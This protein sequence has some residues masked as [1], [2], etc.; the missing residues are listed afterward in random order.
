[1]I[2]QKKLSQN[3]KKGGFR[4]LFLPKNDF[5]SCSA[6]SFPKIMKILKAW[7]PANDMKFRLIFFFTYPST[8][9]LII[10]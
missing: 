1:M 3:P 7:K 8:Y 9:E 10:R 5:K 6:V 4:E 2:L